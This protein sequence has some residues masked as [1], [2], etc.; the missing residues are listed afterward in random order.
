MCMPLQHTQTFSSL[1]IPQSHILILTATD[2]PRF[3]RMKGDRPYTIAMALQD[4]QT[5]L[6]L[7][8][9]Q[10]HRP[11]ETCAGQHP[12]VRV[13]CH[14]P[15]GA[16]MTLQS[17]QQLSGSRV[18]YSDGPVKAAAH[19]WRPGSSWSAKVVHFFAATDRISGKIKNVA[20]VSKVPRIIQNNS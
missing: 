2:D 3:Y 16:S 14:A 17:A 11:V 5:L 12:P 19:H 6:S 15:D 4:M 13:Q 9:P 20:E 1:H 7:H 10:T 8:I 18:P